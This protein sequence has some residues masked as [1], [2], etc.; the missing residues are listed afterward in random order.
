M[1]AQSRK[2]QEAGSLVEELRRRMPGIRGAKFVTTEGTGKRHSLICGKGSASVSDEPKMLLV[3]L[4]LVF[5]ERLV[6]RIGL[7]LPLVEENCLILQVSI[8]L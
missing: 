7:F 2:A 3:A 1:S 6:S 4:K 5:P 8:P